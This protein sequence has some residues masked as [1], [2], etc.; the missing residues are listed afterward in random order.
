MSRIQLLSAKIANLIAAGE[1]VERPASVIKEL[2]EN[3][4]D[5]GATKI[6][7]NVLQA[8]RALIIVSD[9]GSG[10][11]GDDI[12]LAFVRHAT[13]KIKSEHD[14][15]R[16]QTL[17][18][19]G[20]ALPSIAAVAKVTAT[21][22]LVDG[23]GYQIVLEN[24]QVVSEKVV[25]SPKGTTI[26][27][28]HLFLQTPA[29]LKHLKSDYT[30][31]A[32]LVDAVSH[33]ALGHPEIRIECM[34]DGRLVYRTPGN[35]NLLDTVTVIYGLET[36]KQLIPIQGANYD[37]KVEG[38][39]SNP[40][41]TKSNRYSMIY[42][43][44]GRP[45][46]LPIA[47]TKVM[48]A[49]HTFVPEGRYPVVILSIKTDPVLTDINVHPSKHEVRLSKEESLGELLVGLV[50]QALRSVAYP[51]FGHI[52]ALPTSPAI[53]PMEITYNATG[54]T[55]LFT[56]D[57]LNEVVQETLPSTPQGFP[58]NLKPIAQLHQTYII[59]SSEQG[60]Y[61]IDQHAA[62]ERINYERLQQVFINE[63]Q[64]TQVLG[65]PLL[66]EFPYADVVKL[67]PHLPLLHE[68]GI[69]IEI[70]GTQA[71]R[72][73]EIP[74]WMMNYNEHDVI[75][76]ALHR[77]LQSQP[78]TSNHLRDHAIATMS[79]KTSLKANKTLALSEMESLISR[80][81]VCENPFT[82]PH[83]RPTMVFY[84]LYNLEH[85]FKRV[86]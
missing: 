56:N 69:H 7:I 1:V 68:L 17:G 55:S 52:S 28:E 64:K 5:A 47:F 82:C 38:F 13:S 63:P 41:L 10:M 25:A 54:E 72:V 85:T 21:S 33:A 79:C 12:K 71:I 83:G 48:Q 15:F 67:T 11:D 65:V 31:T 62:M 76:Y 78:V 9:D 27:V 74:T 50:D 53:S 44:N 14:L 46:R 84:S 29:R 18:F 86:S 58:R 75:D 22:A 32:A 6:T 80:L 49:Y 81:S 57:E 35:R 59:A 30:E 8:G 24:N 61:L 39:V 51:Q 60:F 20:E 23:Q 42:L 73:L 3:S 2:I 26:T 37:F 4:I 36:S 70:F 66:I 19:R 16:I 40:T 45:V 43:L 34:A 77:L